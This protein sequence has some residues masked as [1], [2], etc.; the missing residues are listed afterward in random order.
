MKEKIEQLK[1][2]AT[3]RASYYSNIGFIELANTFTNILTILDEMEKI[4]P[5]EEAAKENDDAV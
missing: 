5:K 3:Q 4:M 2:I 1:S